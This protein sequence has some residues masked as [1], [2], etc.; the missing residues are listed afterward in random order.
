MKSVGSLLKSPFLILSYEYEL[1]VKELDRPT[2]YLNI[3]QKQ[4][5]AKV[6]ISQIQPR[7]LFKK[8][9]VGECNVKNAF[10][11]FPYVLFR[12]DTVGQK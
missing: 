5:S 11:C 8:H 12:V 4:Q 6:Q 10:F 9:M 1:C 3:E 2:P 7:Y